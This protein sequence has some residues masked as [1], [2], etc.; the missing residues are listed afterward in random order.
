MYNSILSLT[1]A[2]DEDVC[3]TLHFSQFAPGKDAVPLYMRLGGSQGLSGPV[4]KISP[5]PGFVPRIVQLVASRCT[6]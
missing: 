1:S 5:P 4:W 2:L 3:S 6:E